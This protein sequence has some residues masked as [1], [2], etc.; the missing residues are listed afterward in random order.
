[1]HIVIAASQAGRVGIVNEKGGNIL[2]LNRKM[3]ATAL[4]GNDC[5][6]WV[7]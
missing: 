1:M 4:S 5:S 2:F 7:L 3:S 6:L